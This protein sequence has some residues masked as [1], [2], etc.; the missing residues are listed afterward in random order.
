MAFNGLIGTTASIKQRHQLFHKH[1]SHSDGIHLDQFREHL[2]ELT[3]QIFTVLLHLSEHMLTRQQRI[4]PGIGRGVDISGEVSAHV[5]HAVHHQV[6]GQTIEHV[7]D[8][9]TDGIA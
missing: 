9:L 7:A 4:E 8:G 1:C 2:S 5:I 6:I 3:R